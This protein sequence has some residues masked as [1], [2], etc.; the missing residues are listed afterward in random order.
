MIMVVNKAA[1]TR[2]NDKTFNK[3]MEGCDVV[4]I[5]GNASEECW[6]GKDLKWEFLRRIDA[7]VARGTVVQNLLGKNHS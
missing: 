2:N 3:A 7:S 4:R 5:N 6:L 1:G